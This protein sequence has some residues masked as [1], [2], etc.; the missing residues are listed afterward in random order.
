MNERQLPGLP[1]DLP[2]RSCK[3]PSSRSPR[4]L[5]GLRWR[6][7]NSGTDGAE[8]ATRGEPA[9]VSNLERTIADASTPDSAS[10]ERLGPGDLRRA[11][12]APFR[13]T[14]VSS[15]YATRAAT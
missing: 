9:S 1:L 2:S 12:A 8:H 15:R 6:D 13:R 14:T 11:R 4:A 3:G 5:L 10:E 7:L